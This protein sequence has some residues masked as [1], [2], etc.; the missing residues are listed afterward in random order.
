MV[1][2]LDRLVQFRRAGT[3]QTAFGPRE[4]VFADHGSP[5]WASKQDVSDGERWRAG[6]VSAQITTRFVVRWTAFTAALRPTDQL[7]CGG[8]TYE[9]TGIKEPLG[10]RQWLEITT[11]AQVDGNED[12][13]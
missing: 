8:V 3:I 2:S 12:Q 11:A 4:G 9:I 7:V 10:R 6:Q 13:D 1:R 5:V